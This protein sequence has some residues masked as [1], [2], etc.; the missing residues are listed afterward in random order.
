[1]GA[2]LKRKKLSSDER[3]DL[4]CPVHTDYLPHM[5]GALKVKSILLSV[6]FLFRDGFISV[7]RSHLF[8][9]AVELLPLILLPSQRSTKFIPRSRCS[10]MI[11]QLKTHGGGGGV[12][13]VFDYMDEHHNKVCLH[14][15]AS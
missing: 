12:K 15:R 7:K 10:L 13:R 5:I 4:C 9:V 1:M 2:G 14:E 8:K 3:T 6:L 11:R